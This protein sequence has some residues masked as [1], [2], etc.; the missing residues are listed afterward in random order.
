M[1]ERG[2]QERIVSSWTSPSRS[3]SL[4][5]SLCEQRQPQLASDHSVSSSAVDRP[6]YCDLPLDLFSLPFIFS[7]F[8]RPRRLL[9]LHLSSPRNAAMAQYPP[10]SSLLKRTAQIT[11]NE[12]HNNAIHT[13][14]SSMSEKT[15]KGEGTSSVGTGILTVRRGP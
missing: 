5:D 11:T 8:L 7:F 15:R 3:P 1:R 6:Y 4:A 9:F 12:H 10:N 14:K 13:I 2:D